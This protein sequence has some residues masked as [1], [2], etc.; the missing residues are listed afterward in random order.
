MKASDIARFLDEPLIGPDI[1]VTAVRPVHR[2]TPGALG[3]AGRGMD[4]VTPEAGALVLIRRKADTGASTG[5]SFIR[6]DRPR[7]AFARVVAAGV[8]PVGQ[9]EY[10]REDDRRACEGERR[11]GGHHPGP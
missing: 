8:H 10:R 5:N 3:F 1:D 6:V 11:A 2:L 7:E 9:D 4:E